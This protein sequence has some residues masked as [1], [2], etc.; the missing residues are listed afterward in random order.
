MWKL[1]DEKIIASTN[2]RPFRL[3]RQSANFAATLDET[4][5]KFAGAYNPST[6]R[7][8][9]ESKILPLSRNKL[10]IWEVKMVCFPHVFPGC[11]S[12]IINDFAFYT[13]P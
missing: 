9:T 5:G 10:A 13:V 2:S 3:G 4:R 12:A 1:K 11:S 8:T 7:N 6:L